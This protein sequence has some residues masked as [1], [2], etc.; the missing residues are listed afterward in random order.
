MSFLVTTPDVT[1]LRNQDASV[2]DETKTFNLLGKQVGLFHAAVF[3]DNVLLQTEIT[4]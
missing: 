1:L 2:T 3:V 4:Y